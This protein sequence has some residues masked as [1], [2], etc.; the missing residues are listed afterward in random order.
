MVSDSGYACSSNH[1]SPDFGKEAASRSPARQ[2]ADPL[3]L[4]PTPI[5]AHG[6]M[7]QEVGEEDQEIDIRWKWA[8][9]SLMGRCP[10]TDVSG[11]PNAHLLKQLWDV[12]ETVCADHDAIH[13]P[14]SLVIAPQRRYGYK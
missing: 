9:A 3:G 10:T 8:V 2:D 4:R 6:I 5:A 14:C 12:S 11:N 13:W 7:V 1:E